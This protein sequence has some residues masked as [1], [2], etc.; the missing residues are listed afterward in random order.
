MS[1]LFVVPDLAASKERLIRT[2]AK[3]CPGVGERKRVRTKVCCPPPINTINMRP[4]YFTG[5]NRVKFMVCSINI[6]RT[7]VMPEPEVTGEAADVSADIKARPIERL[8]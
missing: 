7:H 2:T 1:E 3:S 5:A 6:H 4:V 8:G